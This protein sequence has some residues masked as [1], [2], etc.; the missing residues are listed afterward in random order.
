M[1][2]SHRVTAITSNNTYL[3][4]SPFFMLHM[5][6]TILY[7]K[8]SIMPFSNKFILSLWSQISIL[9][10]YLIVEPQSFFFFFTTKKNEWEV[11]H[12]DI[13]P[14]LLEY[15]TESLK[16]LHI[17]C[18]SVCVWITYPYPLNLYIYISVLYYCLFVLF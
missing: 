18:V 16:Y 4:C 3:M 13:K 1:P 6:V 15:K 8:N 9:N 11:E 14:Y 12:L 7:D 5:R 2:K 10:A 17:V